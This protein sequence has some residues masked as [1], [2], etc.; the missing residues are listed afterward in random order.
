MKFIIAAVVLIPAAVA[1]YSFRSSNLKYSEAY[2]MYQ[3]FAD[4]YHH[5]RIAECR[6]LSDGPAMKAAVDARE[7]RFFQLA[8]AGMHDAS[9]ASVMAIS[10][11]KLSQSSPAD[12]T[13]FLDTHMTIATSIS[14]L[15][16]PKNVPHIKYRHAVTLKRTASGWKIVDFTET[17]ESEVK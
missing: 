15:S 10:Y 6:T 7:Q 4:A 2:S 13:V 5:D 9:M 12:D 1:G 17:V 8:K 3:R 14:G 16:A 11:N